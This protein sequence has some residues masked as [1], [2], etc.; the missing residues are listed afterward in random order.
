[1]DCHMKTTMELSDA[2]LQTS[3]ELA[4]KSQTTMR[5]LVHEALCRV[6]YDEHAKTQP[7]FRL[8]DASVQGE[9]MLISNL[10]L[11][12][13]LNLSTKHLV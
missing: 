7:A 12:H 10:R 4:N 9:E 6:L 8:K 5:A 1:M 11:W 2:L 13:E 3:K